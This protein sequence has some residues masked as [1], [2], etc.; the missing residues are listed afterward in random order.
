MISGCIVCDGTVN[1]KCIDLG[2]IPLVNNFKSLPQKKK[3]KLSMGL[4]RKCKLFQ[5]QK[6]I[7]PKLLFNNY[8]HVSSGSK[9]NLEHIEKV[10]KKICKIKDV[11]NQTKILE[12]GCN[13]GSLLKIAKKKTKKIVGIDPAKNLVKKIKDNYLE[14]IPDFFDRRS[15][16][17][18]ISKYNKFDVI[19]ALNVIPHT[20][21]VK[22]IIEYVSKL[23]SDDGI[24]FMEGAY[25][26]ETIYKGK[27]DTIYHEHV[28]SFTLHSLKN[29]L[30]NYNLKIHFAEKISTQGG[31]IRVIAKKKTKSLQWKK[32]YNDEKKN[33]VE[34]LQ[35]YKRTGELIKKIIKSINI[36]YK[37]ISKYKKVVLLGAPARGVV[38]SNVCQ[39]KNNKLHF[40]IDD[41]STKYNK[42]FP[43][44]K[45][46]VYN[47]KKLNENDFSNFILLSWNYEKEILKKIKL[48]RKKFTL[49]VP[50]PSPKIINYS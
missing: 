24:F 40:A 1:D 43:G 44:T 23:L 50:L 37:Q 45:I 8:A 28:S 32:I 26:F 10:F 17:Y 5:V 36:C 47:W 31:S 30:D 39:F 21:N 42:F 3:Y 19:I 6:N 34:E 27:F 2:S 15:G 29:L 25:F 20:V 48:Y 38:I 46:K 41:S 18:L 4:C 49:M 22:D 13:D 11:N 7:N 9:S 12:I 35:T 33:G 16:E 14:L